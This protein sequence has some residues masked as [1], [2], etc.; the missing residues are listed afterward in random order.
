MKYAI[1]T[2]IKNGDSFEAIFDT[3]K[4]AV[5]RADYEWGIMSDHDKKR[6]EFCAVMEGE[7][8]EDGC[9]DMDSARIVKEYK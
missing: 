1:I 7:V 6:R 3:E 9:F 5:A 2:E 8:D 4:E